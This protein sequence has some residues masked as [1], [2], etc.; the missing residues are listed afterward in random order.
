MTSKEH[1]EVITKTLI[2]LLCEVYFMESLLGSIRPLRSIIRANRFRQTNIST[3]QK[4]FD[5]VLKIM[6]RLLITKREL[7]NDEEKSSWKSYVKYP[8][9]LMPLIM[10]KNPED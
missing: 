7:Q 3:C 8:G 2:H 5:K 1:T 10:V 4:Y 6:N 9:M